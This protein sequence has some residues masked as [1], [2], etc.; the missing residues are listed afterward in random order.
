MIAC[1]PIP[2]AFQTNHGVARRKADRMKTTRR[3][4]A[5]WRSRLLRRRRDIVANSYCL[6]QWPD[7]HIAG[8]LHLAYNTLDNNKSPTNGLYAELKQDFAGVGGD[9]DFIRSTADVRTYTEVFPDVVGVLHLQGGNVSSW[10]GQQLRSLDEFQMGPNLVRGF[11]PSGFGPRDID[12]LRRK[13]LSV[14]HCIGV[15]APSCRH[16]SISCR[17]R[18]ASRFQPLPTSARLWNYQGRL[19]WGVTGETSTVRRTS[20]IR[21]SVGVGIIWDSPLGPLRFDF[22]EAID[23]AIYDRTQFF[24]FS[25]GQSSN[26][27]R[28]CGA[29]HWPHDR[30]GI[31]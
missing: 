22:A 1:R 5:K 15:R 26:C 3:S 8:R 7:D 24:R 16:R 31:P 23:K 10:G 9:V 13:M 6:G 17:R 20:A 4:D 14:A 29:R 30:A 25:G 12:L 19:H 28:R 27:V 21:S 2:A 18:S 11:A